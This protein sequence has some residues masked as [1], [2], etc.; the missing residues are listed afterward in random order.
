M[1]DRRPYHHGDLRAALLDAALAV[2]ERDGH[3]A[4]S[5]RD[6]AQRVGV[7]RAAPYRHFDDRR[8]L[9]SAVAGEG[10]RA[11]GEIYQRVAREHAAPAARLRAGARAFL[12]FA[13]VRSEL[14]RLMFATDLLTSATQ[15]PHPDLIAPA[16]AAYAMLERGVAAT[17]PGAD[18]KTIK[19][20]TIAMW[21]TVH[22]F[23]VLRQGRR[24][25]PFMLGALGEDELIE[26]VLS[27]A[28]GDR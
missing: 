16:D 21:S 6:L 20:R 3:E 2:V 5:L 14:F 10:F 11:L 28:L 1:T 13:Q 19:A 8:A 27:A 23:A 18:D 15:A 12:E 26:A 9:L 22:G 4:L 7:S 17:L 24:L 25:K